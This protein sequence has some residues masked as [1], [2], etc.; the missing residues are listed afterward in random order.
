MSEEIISNYYHININY[1]IEL[2]TKKEGFNWLEI[3]NNCVCHLKNINKIINASK[4]IDRITI[5]DFI[6]GI[7]ANIYI[8]YDIFR[9]KGIKFE[10]I[11]NDDDDDDLNFDF[12]DIQ[13]IIDINKC[14]KKELNISSESKN[15][16]LNNGKYL[17]IIK[18]F[19]FKIYNTDEDMKNN[20][21]IQSLWKY[22]IN[23]IIQKK[24]NKQICINDE[25]EFKFYD[26]YDDI[27]SFISLDNYKKKIG[28]YPFDYFN[29]FIQSNQIIDFYSMFKNDSPI[30]I[31]IKYLL[32]YANKIKNNKRITIKQYKEISWFVSSLIGISTTK[33]TIS[34]NNEY[35][36]VIKSLKIDA[37][38]NGNK[39]KK[40]EYID[41][42]NNINTLFSV[43]NE[44]NKPTD[45]LNKIKDEMKYSN[46]Y[47]VLKSLY[48]K[49]NLSSSY[50]KIFDNNDPDNLKC[51][52]STPAAANDILIIKNNNDDDNDNDNDNDDDNDNDNDN[53]ND[54]DND[55]DND[56]D[57]DDN[58]INIKLNEDN[59]ITYNNNEYELDYVLF[60]N[61]MKYNIVG[62]MI[63]N[64]KYIYD[65]SKII[66]SANN[67][68]TDG[69]CALTQF[70]WNENIL[71]NNNTCIYNNYS[72][73]YVIRKSKDHLYILRNIPYHYYV[74]YDNSKT[75]YV[76][77]K[78]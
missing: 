42:N 55:N 61:N 31:F 4:D 74:C 32:I 3:V 48:S 30:L 36:T 20:K 47:S 51:Y 11:D 63:N 59:K 78:I 60:E 75:T 38:G 9:Y 34:A 5:N 70:E 17:N 71:N 29:C 28:L 15:K 46:N 10:K 77:H 43:N 18:D 16:F 69:K 19:L 22:Y 40:D 56:N 44:I 23:N 57:N 76:Y 37:N 64:N 54:D 53:N 35:A 67:N 39:P 65:G 72:C 14:E 33:K 50:L 8:L 26:H 68:E 24:F 2:L 62:L 12:N 7:Y 49:L 27:F 66:L 6:F 41:I 25:D 21:N 13:D 58:I 45:L 1:V 52:S 73:E